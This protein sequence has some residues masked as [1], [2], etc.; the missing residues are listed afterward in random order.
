MIEY[1]FKKKLQMMS[2][3]KGNKTVYKNDW[4]SYPIFDLLFF[5]S[6]TVQKTLILEPTCMAT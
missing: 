1:F 5:L 4:V 6:V 3:K 2:Q